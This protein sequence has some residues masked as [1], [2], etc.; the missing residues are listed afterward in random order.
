MA[1]CNAYAHSLRSSDHRLQDKTIQ[2]GVPFFVPH[3]TK[4]KTNVM[5]QAQQ[6]LHLLFPHEQQAQQA[7]ASSA[8][9]YRKQGDPDLYTDTNLRK[10]E[11]LQSDP[12]VLGG[13]A[14]FWDTFPC[15]RQGHE[16][17]VQRDYV[18]V[19]MKCFKALV[20]PSE[21]SVAEAKRIVEKDWERDMGGDP[22]ATMSRPQFERALFEVADIWTV[23]IGAELYRSFLAKLFDRVTMT[24][25]DQEKAAWLTVF[26]DLDKVRSF[27]DTS[28]NQDGHTSS[29]MSLPPSAV[30]P[31]LIKPRPPLLKKK[32]SL[33]AGMDS[34]L[35]SSNEARTAAAAATGG[36]GSL[37]RLPDVL[38]MP[39]G[40]AGLPGTKSRAAADQS[41]SSGDRSPLVTSRSDVVVKSPLSKIISGA[42]ANH[43]SATSSSSQP[44]NNE[45]NE[46]PSPPRRQRVR[47]SPVKSDATLN[48]NRRTYLYS[49]SAEDGTGASSPTRSELPPQQIRLPMPSIYLSPDLSQ[50][51]ATERAARRR[52]RQSA[53]LAHRLRRI[54]F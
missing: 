30:S 51:R 7:S 37:R 49:S 2:E 26:S 14:R 45:D 11:Q 5:C 23:G 27:A 22:A 9:S 48:N 43:P 33:L 32:P 36:G 50:S 20:A 35:N 12:L 28:P 8:S 15:V 1:S 6:Q 53:K 38:P 47:S 13:I 3:L 25:Y 21:F 4:V 10:R 29:Q 42:K 39:L 44:G 18:D 46:A 34:S 19:L 31:V 41:Y 40:N 17:L 16:T 24:V 52:I 54:T